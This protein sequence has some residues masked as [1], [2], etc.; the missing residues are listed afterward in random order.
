MIQN[1]TKKK[2]KRVS[3]VIC[4]TAI[5]T[6]VISF[7]LGAQTTGAFKLHVGEIKVTD[8]RFSVADYLF[9]KFLTQGRAQKCV[10]EG[11]FEAFVLRVSQ[12]FVVLTICSIRKHILTFFAVILCSRGFFQRYY[13]NNI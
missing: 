4:Q 3:T 9:K 12:V 6:F 1:N 5:W 8:F 2:D 10:L 11:N 13:R 7:I